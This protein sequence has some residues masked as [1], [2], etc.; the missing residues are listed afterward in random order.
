LVRVGQHQLPL[1]EV[2]VALLTGWIGFRELVGSGP[3]ELVVELWS[4]PCRVCKRPM[5]V[6]EVTEVV[7]GAWGGPRRGLVGMRCG[8]PS[9]CKVSGG[10]RTSR[11]GFWFGSG[12]R[13][14]RC[15][16]AG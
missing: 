1:G 9:H 4:P 5:A 14:W 16:D 10:C 6:W 8:G 2:V 13:R 7:T 11:G 12:Y 15:C 3:G